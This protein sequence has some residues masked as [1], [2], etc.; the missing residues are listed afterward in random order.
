[1]YKFIRKPGEPPIQENDNTTP[2]N[3]II[4]LT[5]HELRICTAFFRLLNE[6]YTKQID[7]KNSPEQHWS[8]PVVDNP[9]E[10][11]T[12]GDDYGSP[13]YY[14]E[15][16]KT[17]VRHELLMQDCKFDL[18]NY[19]GKNNITDPRVQRILAREIEQFWDEL[20]YANECAEA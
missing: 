9:F 1:M 7:P 4:G 3:I 8:V 19:C 2:R 10:I 12:P 15:D 14:I 13:H 16:H 11:S 17:K 18:A 6:Y 5:Q 20:A